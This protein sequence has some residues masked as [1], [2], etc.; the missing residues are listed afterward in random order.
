LVTP[1]ETVAAAPVVVA[2]VV[3]AVPLEALVLL[4]LPLPQPANATRATRAIPN[5]ANRLLVL[6]WYLLGVCQ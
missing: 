5:A 4:V 1:V 2:G 3:V 6:T